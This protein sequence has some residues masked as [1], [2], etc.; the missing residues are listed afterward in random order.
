MAKAKAKNIE[1]FPFLSLL[2]VSIITIIFF[3]FIFLL[4]DCIE[5]QNSPSHLLVTYLLITLPPNVDW[6]R[7]C[8]SS[9]VVSDPLPG[10]PWKLNLS[11]TRA[12]VVNSILIGPFFPEFYGTWI[13][14]RWNG[15]SPRIILDKFLAGF[16]YFVWNWVL[17]RISPFWLEMPHSFFTFSTTIAP[18]NGVFSSYKGHSFCLTE[19]W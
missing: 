7:R 9:M 17:A 12:I 10:T 16:G 8:G 6:F 19:V 2:T 13:G 11:W 18:L 1:W 4:E 15:T 3:F 14:P 5:S